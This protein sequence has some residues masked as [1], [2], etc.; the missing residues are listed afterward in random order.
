MAV[1]HFTGGVFMVVREKSINLFLMDGKVEGRIKCA[2]AN[3]TGTAYKI[4]ELILTCAKTV[5][6]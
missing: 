4:L 3:W 5:R 1:I 6:T 2:L